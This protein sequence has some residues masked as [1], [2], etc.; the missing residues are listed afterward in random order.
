LPCSSAAPG[1]PRRNPPGSPCAVKADLVS[2]DSRV[3]VSGKVQEDRRSDR[4][5][6]SFFDKGHEEPLAVACIHGTGEGGHHLPP[7]GK[8]RNP[9][10]DQ[11][12]QDPLSCPLSRL[13]CSIS[14]SLIITTPGD[15][16]GAE[17]VRVTSREFA[18]RDWATARSKKATVSPAGMMTK[19]ARPTRKGRRKQIDHKIEGHGAQDRDQPFSFRRFPVKTVFFLHSYEELHRLVVFHIDSP[20]YSAPAGHARTDHRFLSPVH[21]PSSRT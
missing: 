5:C 6:E 4:S 8:A 21:F 3:S 7:P 10:A 17:A 11:D 14:L 13:A 20:C 19:E 1:N 15:H 9:C 16:P 12:R 2:R 18:L